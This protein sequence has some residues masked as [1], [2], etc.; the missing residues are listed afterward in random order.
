[1]PAKMA[2][3]GYIKKAMALNAEG[4]KAPPRAHPSSARGLLQELLI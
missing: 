2:P 3:A 1:M 4:G